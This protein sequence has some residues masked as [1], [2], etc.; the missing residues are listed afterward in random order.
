MATNCD[1][2]GLRT[3][4]VKS[5]GGIEPTGIRITV[6]VRNK[7]DLSRDILKVLLYIFYFNFYIK[8]G[9]N[10]YSLVNTS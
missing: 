5:S 7:E 4:E 8:T 1:V 10:T 3:N 6:K 2:C 9:C